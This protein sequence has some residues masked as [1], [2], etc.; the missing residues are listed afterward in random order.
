VD[1]GIPSVIHFHPLSLEIQEAPMI[2]VIFTNL[3]N[4]RTGAME[5]V[6]S[7]GVDI[8]TLEQFTLPP[9]TAKELGAFYSPDLGEFVVSN[10]P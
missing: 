3:R 4:E 1:Y 6:A 8:D 7:H 10:I 5:R 9:V 2:V